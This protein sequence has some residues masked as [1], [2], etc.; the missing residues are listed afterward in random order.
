LTTLH[1]IVQRAREREGAE[2]G[3]S[4]AEWLAVRAAAH[5]ALA[6]QHS[7]LALYDLRET[8]E[9]AKAPL[10]VEFVAAMTSIGDVSCLE[11]V[12]GAY[13]RAA[14]DAPAREDWWRRSLADVFRAIVEREDLT[15]RHAV[16]KK[17][18]KR[19]PGLFRSLLEH[20]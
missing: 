10:A 6:Q 9:G 14:K 1:Q 20:R 8:V 3:E 19:W 17:I 4:R 2:A 7:R 5:A 15:A 12:A 11:A 16:A 18:E 13:G